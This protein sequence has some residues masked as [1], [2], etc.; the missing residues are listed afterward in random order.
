MLY[1]TVRM[2]TAV[3]S[4]A[5]RVSSP[6]AGRTAGQSVRVQISVLENCSERKA[7]GQGL[8]IASAHVLHQD[9]GSACLRKRCH[10][11]RKGQGE[12]RD[13]PSKE[14]FACVR[15]EVVCEWYGWMWRA[16]GLV[17]SL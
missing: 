12:S 1:A 8:S 10:A 3:T 9:S 13:A 7:V 11:C 2:Q 4:M 16:W 15:R 17:T 14:D 6:P 5:G